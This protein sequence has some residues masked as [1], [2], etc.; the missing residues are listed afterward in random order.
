MLFAHEN[1]DPG[2][3]QLPGQHGY[4][5]DITTANIPFTPPGQSGNHLCLIPQ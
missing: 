4:P 2:H 5:I 1:D 3:F